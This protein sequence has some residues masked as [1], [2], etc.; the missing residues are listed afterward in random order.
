MLVI[1]R[2]GTPVASSVGVRRRASPVSAAPTSPIGGVW[3]VLS[4]W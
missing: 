3:N 1:T 4:C 2:T